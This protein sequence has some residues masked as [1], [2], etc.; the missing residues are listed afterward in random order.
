MPL[1]QVVV[2]QSGPLPIQIP[3]KYQAQG[4][5]MLFLS[6]TA[7][8]ANAGS[9][10]GVEVLIDGNSVAAA[11]VVT[12]EANSHK[13]LVSAFFPLD[14]DYGDHKMMVSV[15]GAGQTDA[16]DFFNVS[17]LYY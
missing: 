7:F 5:A 15:L 1:A 17:I 8:T 14:L 4:P 16:N 9:A 6:G 11:E 3:F 2:N 12:N 13:T 10:I